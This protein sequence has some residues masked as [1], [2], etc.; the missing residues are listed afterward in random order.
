[1]GRKLPEGWNFVKFEDLVEI[2]DSKRKPINST[3]RANMLWDIPYYWAT[4]KAWTINDYIFDE[5]LVLLW[6]D[7][8][9]FINKDKDVA[10]LISWKSWV[11]NHAHVLKWK[12]WLSNKWLCYFLN[13][14]DYSNRV[15]W[16][17]RMKL[18]QAEMKKIKILFS[19]TEQEKIVSYL[20]KQFAFIDNMEEQINDYNN[21]LEKLEKG[22]LE[23]SFW[24]KNGLIKIENLFKLSSW[25]FL[26]QEEQNENWLYDI[27]WWNWIIWKSNNFDIDWENIVIWRVWAKA[28]NVRL[29]NWKSRISDNALYISSYLKDFY[30]KYLYWNLI[31]L[32]LNSK[33]SVVNRPLIS[34]KWIKDFEIYYPDL[35][36]QKLIAYKL[37]KQFE[38][39]NSTRQEIDNQKKNLK[40]L[41]KAMLNDIFGGFEE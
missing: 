6:E 4:W 17:T 29:I 10:Y 27:Y 12:N 26:E 7:W 35:Q 36:T 40:E 38:L 5:E 28:W 13:S 11:N 32:D 25:N 37:D 9:D 24:N 3:E 41:R 19:P 34:Y 39:I 20:D 18:N 22:I 8:A 14:I 21:K 2:L 23:E 30:K 1:M 33:A 31:Y 16:A 15:A